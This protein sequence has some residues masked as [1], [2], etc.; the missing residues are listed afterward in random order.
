MTITATPIARL[1][2]A[3]LV[4]AAL[5]ATVSLSAATGAEAAGPR[6]SFQTPLTCGQMW[7]ATTYANHGP[8]P[9][10]IDLGMWDPDNVNISQGEPVLA[11]AD[12]TVTAVGINSKNENF[13]FLDHGNGWT[14]QHT[15]LE[16]IPPLVVG[17]QVAQGEQIGRVANTGQQPVE[18]HLHWTRGLA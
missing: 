5:A 2:S 13:V 7:G 12:G 6:P 1:K 3:K 10:S 11:S 18:F 16:S 4:A 14:T 9:D 17:Q 15:H 8:D